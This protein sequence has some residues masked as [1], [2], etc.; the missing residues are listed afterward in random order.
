MTLGLFIIIIFLALLACAV[1]I[2][3]MFFAIV[4]V[5]A[6]LIGTFIIWS[7]ADLEENYFFCI[8][9]IAGVCYAYFRIV[10]DLGIG[11]GN[12]GI[13]ITL[14]GVGLSFFE[15]WFYKL[16]SHIEKSN[17]VL[18]YSL[19]I[20]AAGIFF[21]ADTK[22][23]DVIIYQDRIASA[24]K[25]VD[26]VRTMELK[27]DSGI[28]EEQ[29]DIIGETKDNYLYNLKKGTV[30][31]CEKII[32]QTEGNILNAKD[33]VYGYKVHTD[34]G[35]VGFVRVEQVN[36]LDYATVYDIQYS[37]EWDERYGE[38]VYNGW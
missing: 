22:G 18:G 35:K 12:V 36:L 25:T 5:L 21:I 26:Y 15:Y 10:W 24:K 20:I 14:I 37:E 8:I 13:G 27:E 9:A 29:H 32:E 30:L 3:S 19:A 23:I 4:G 6:I 7:T 2:T 11:N 34:D 38:E 16:L 33:I 1:L 31:W 17:V 28:Y